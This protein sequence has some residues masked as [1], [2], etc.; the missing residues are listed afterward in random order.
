MGAEGAC[1]LTPSNEL[2]NTN[3][4]VNTEIFAN[5]IET[6]PEGSCPKAEMLEELDMGGL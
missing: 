5:L 6:R 4:S 1:W 3:V 2:V